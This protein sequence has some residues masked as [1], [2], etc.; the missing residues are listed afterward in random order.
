MDDVS[1]LVLEQ[2][3]LQ[4]L[5]SLFTSDMIYDIS[6]EDIALLAGETSEAVAERVRLREKKTT[7]ESGLQE[8]R[9]LDKHRSQTPYGMLVS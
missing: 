8:L 7:L 6:D 1:I 5:P 9:R 3:L 4:K 2:C